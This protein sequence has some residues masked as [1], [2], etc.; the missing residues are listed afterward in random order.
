MIG[1]MHP[2]YKYIIKIPSDIN[3]ICKIYYVFGQNMRS[4]TMMIMI[5]ILAEPIC[6]KALNYSSNNC[7]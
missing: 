4:S 7:L 5:Y 2:I 3:K 6:C 1:E